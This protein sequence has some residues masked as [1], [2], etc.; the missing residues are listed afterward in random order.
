MIYVRRKSE[1]LLK[2][3]LFALALAVAC[4]L[5]AVADPAPLAVGSVRDTDGL[6]VV[7]G[8]VRAYDG[9]GASV[10][11][12]TTDAAGTF[13][14]PLSAQAAS[15]VVT[16]AYC[17]KKQVQ[18]VPGAGAMPLVV[19]VLRY[20]ALFGPVL[21]QRDFAAL[22]YA[23]P[24]Q[25]I[26][27]AP[28]VIPVPPGPGGY[29][30][31][32]SDR[33]LERGFGLVVDG[34]APAYDLVHG[35]SALA[36]FPAGSVQTVH[37]EPATDAYR[38]GS[39]AGGGT[40]ILD[41]VGA[42]AAAGAANTG[43]DASLGGYARLGGFTPIAAISQGDQLVNRRAS[44][45]YDSDFAGGVLRV[46]AT[47]SDEQAYAGAFV[48]STYSDILDA[49]YATASRRYRTFVDASAS[50]TG[51]DDQTTIVPQNGRSSQLIGSFRLEHPGPITTALGIVAQQYTGSY[52][53][54]YTST[55]SALS[56]RDTDDLIYLQAQGGNRW[57][58]FD[59]GAS[60]SQIALDEYQ[61]SSEKSASTTTF[62]PSL[63][64]DVPL[65]DAFAL[66]AAASRSLR[67]PTLLE[68][69]VDP[70]PLSAQPLEYGS[71]TQEGL[72][73][74]DGHRVRA[75][76]TLFHENLDGF[77]DRS[78]T[79]LGF[80]LTWQLAPLLSL[81]A[82][83][84]HDAAQALT[85]QIPTTPYSAI[86]VSRA[87]GWASYDNQGAFR[88]DLIVRRDLADSN[89]ET[90]VDGDLVVRLFKGLDATAGTSRFN[91]RRTVYFG[92]RLPLRSH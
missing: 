55:L 54:T 47:T 15:V 18:I 5:V 88:V 57:I 16:C 68:L 87:V 22:P 65:G 39:Y 73:F 13:A 37:I 34:D 91:G 41:D 67:I 60:V 23:R 49:A 70:Q 46:G 7:G 90:D 4:R 17:A 48:P 77:S 10:G 71:L 24:A 25:A 86:A 11:A 45:D 64:V 21:D 79:G 63:A 33:G 19:I 80:S 89:P 78:T 38:Y 52:T 53:Y 85:P 2:V 66:T 14:L 58:S 42:A 59:A 32:I 43:P 31:D 27:L 40:F 28:Y 6:P 81:R 56:A 26:A 30:A 51:F 8:T 82:W 76:A 72:A 92:L 44:F 84:L 83:T 61:G 36:D 35:G 75:D 69:A 9:R 29:V 74:D 62:L 3:G 20:R 12:G 50:E 1:A